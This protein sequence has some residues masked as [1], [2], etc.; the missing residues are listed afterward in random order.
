MKYDLDAEAIH[1][2]VK[3]FKFKSKNGV[4]ENFKTENSRVFALHIQNLE[5][6]NGGL[7]LPG[8]IVKQ[9][10]DPDKKRYKF[11]SRSKS[12]S[13]DRSG[14]SRDRKR[15]GKQSGRFQSSR[16]DHSPKSGHG[17]NKYSRSRSTSKGRSGN[18]SKRNNSPQNKC[19]HKYFIILGIPRE[20]DTQEMINEI[21]KK[22][23]IKLY[24][25]RFMS[26][27]GIDYLR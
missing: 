13:R 17:Y 20:I 2:G 19:Y 21:Q 10:I 3:F 16:N 1:K 8:Q 24:S 12:Y 7:P 25:Y 5:R 26:H 6:N 9:A 14:S 18:A 23:A 4:F 11:Q 15:S 27:N 22:S